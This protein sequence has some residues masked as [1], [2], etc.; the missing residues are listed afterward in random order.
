MNSGP[1]HMKTP[2]LLFVLSA[3]VSG[4]SCQNGQG[5]TGL[6]S[7]FNRNST[8]EAATP[9]YQSGTW[10]Q[11]PAAAPNY[12]YAQQGY[13]TAQ[14]NYGNAQQNY[15]A[16]QQSNY[17]GWNAGGGSAGQSGSYSDQAQVVPFSENGGNSSYENAYTDSTANV[18]SRPA[19]KR[20]TGR[21]T[22]AT[23]RPET[24]QTSYR[25]DTHSARGSSHVVAKGDTLFSISR[26]YGV[27]V[28]RVRQLNSLNSDTIR[29]GQELVVE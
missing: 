1:L 22:A 14:Q 20:S 27:S 6:S 26:R 16:A 25:G 2:I 7:L 21:V 10:A 8:P 3:A 23:S 12:G 28:N 19:P 24:R 18:T 11:Q 9:A 13:G 5:L 15:G 17:Q 29:I 4:V